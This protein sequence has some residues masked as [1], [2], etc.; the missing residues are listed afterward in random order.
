MS[1]VARGATLAMAGEHDRLRKPPV[2]ET[3]FE[4]RA[5][6]GGSFTFLPGKMAAGLEADYPEVKETDFAKFF[7]LA[8]P[9]PEAGFLATHQYRTSDG[10]QMV[11]LGPVGLSVN[12]L[13][14]PGFTAFRSAVSKALRTYCTHASITAIRRLGLRYVNVLPSGGSSLLEGLTATVK[15]PSLEGSSVKS[16]AAR[17]IFTYSEPSGQLAIAVGAP[18]P[19]GTLLD[20]DFF[21]EPGAAMTEADMLVWTDGAHERVYRA[22]RGMTDPKLFDSWR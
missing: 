19:A 6:I 8:A 3:V 10:K 11:Q 4:L 21:H 1:P 9:P 2:I 12:S 17:G 16:V 7:A 22:F 18:H 14:Y 20:L 13:A 15:W 5:D